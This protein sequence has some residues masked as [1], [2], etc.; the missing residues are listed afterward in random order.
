MR[1][2]LQRLQQTKQQ[3]LARLGQ[4]IHAVQIDKARRFGGVRGSGEPFPRI[5]P[6]KAE[7]GQRRAAE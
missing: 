3:P 2:I 5:A 7:V 1:A 4:K 6:L